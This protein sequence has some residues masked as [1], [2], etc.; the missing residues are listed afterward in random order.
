MPST[1][2]VKYPI[3]DK[4]GQ[5]DHNFIKYGAGVGAT[6]RTMSAKDKELEFKRWQTAILQRIPDQPT[7][8]EL[9]LE[10]RVFALEERRK[11]L[12]NEKDSA[13]T[14]KKKKAQKEQDDSDGSDSDKQSDDDEE[15]SE[16]EKADSDDEDTEME[17]RDDDCR[18]QVREEN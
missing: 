15:E 8:Q 17:E 18:I 14:S 3:L 12:A 16:A 10:N 7:F 2:A 9:G 13:L 11:R 6:H 1:G 4:N 5:D